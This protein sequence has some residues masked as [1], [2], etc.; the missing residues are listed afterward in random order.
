MYPCYCDPALA[1]ISEIHAF[2][3]DCEAVGP[4]CDLDQWFLTEEWKAKFEEHLRRLLPI[5]EQGNP[6]A[7]YF[8]AVI[9]LFGF[10]YSSHKECQDNYEKDTVEGTKWLVRAARQGVVVAIDNLITNGKGPEVERLSKIHFEIQE[11]IKN[12][13]SFPPGETWRRAYGAP[14]S[15]SA[16]HG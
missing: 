5:A 7:Q 6:F 16:K 9:Y 13:A 8:V 10:R 4:I 1:D 12:G 2:H 3:L 15:E 14:V 11:E